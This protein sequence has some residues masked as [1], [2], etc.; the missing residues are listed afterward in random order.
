LA[1]TLARDLVKQKQSWEVFE[2]DQIK[3]FLEKEQVAGTPATPKASLSTSIPA[4]KYESD[5]I[6][7]CAKLDASLV[8]MT[9][10]SGSVEVP[11]L[12]FYADADEKRDVTKT[13]AD[14]KDEMCAGLLAYSTS[15]RNFKDTHLASK[16]AVNGMV[17]KTSQDDMMDAFKKFFA[18]DGEGIDF[19][20]AL[21][22][23]K[24]EL[25]ATEKASQ[26]QERAAASK[27]TATSKLTRVH[28]EHD[29]P[30]TAIALLTLDVALNVVD[31]VSKAVR[32]EAL[33]ARNIPDMFTA[34]T[35]LPQFQVTSKWATT[36]ITKEGSESLS[37]E[38][39]N[40]KLLNATQGL[41]AK[42]PVDSKFCSKDIDFEK[43]AGAL[44][45]ACFQEQYCFVNERYAQIGITPF[46]IG[47]SIYGLSGSLR[48]CGFAFEKLD[49]KN[50]HEKLAKIS[51]LN[52]S[53]LVELC[54]KLGGFMVTI[55]PGTYI[56]VPPCC[57]CCTVALNSTSAAY[58]RWGF[59]HRSDLERVRELITDML[60]CYGFLKDTD[61]GHVL[62]AIEASKPDA[63]A[64]QA[65]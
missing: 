20:A 44:K 3:Y 51:N 29:R 13:F 37:S 23:H 58:M 47:E 19:R 36:Q 25:V 12:E 32:G 35:A 34:I 5:Y 9:G 17:S 16:V 14:L 18:K 11:S 2:Q 33:Y 49:G 6:E 4:S 61:Y 60:N 56:A 63:D 38:I 64:A 8:R 7:K 42:N 1:G 26:K 41:L 57:I 59:L 54:T 22:K 46:G 27:T 43:S 53:Q 15:I 55:N 10:D 50:I 52:A 48:I 30:P 24:K 62:S 40:S 65:D 21:T 31:D 45:M 39:T 28:K